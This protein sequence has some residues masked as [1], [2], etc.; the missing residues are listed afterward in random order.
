MNFVVSDRRTA[1]QLAEPPA[2]HLAST[3]ATNHAVLIPS[4]NTGA[5]L[6]DTV[7]IVRRLDWPVWVIIDGSTDGTGETLARKAA[8]D[9]DLH[10]CVLPH[11]QG[12]GAAVLLGLQRAR[13]HGITHVVTVDADGQHAA[14]DIR[15][16]VTLSRAHPD[17]MV[18]GV[19]VFDASAPKIRV[20]G[21]RISYSLANLVTLRSGIGNPLFGFRIYPIAPLLRAFDETRW[22]RRFDFDSE[23]AI[24]LS[25]QG[26]PAINLP[27]PVRYFRR[28]D[29]GVSH[30]HYLRDNLLL[31]VMYARLF[32]ALVPRLP[33]LLA[34]RF[35]SSRR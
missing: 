18:L 26:V 30:F 5:R 21:H 25:W 8:N 7:A 14:E 34:R 20:A 4:Y 11:N 15:T 35:K 6:Y 1:A 33:R 3:A 13:A 29:G 17:A 23:A 9:A 19:P 16:L 24:R 28:E 12:K 31:M 22:M 32:S 27:T 2:R 10:V